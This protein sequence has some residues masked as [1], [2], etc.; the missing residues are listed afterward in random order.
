[1]SLAAAKFTSE[2]MMHVL[3]K[4]PP[5]HAEEVSEGPALSAGLRAK[6]IAGGE[7]PPSKLNSLNASVGEA[8][9]LP[10]NQPRKL[11]SNKLTISV[12]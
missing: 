5:H 2:A 3:T 8:T 9:F 12:K 6:T 10:S 1:M 11:D 4:S 7:S